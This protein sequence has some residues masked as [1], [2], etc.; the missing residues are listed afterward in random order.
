LWIA[1]SIFINKGY[2]KNI[3]FVFNRF[4][5]IEV[6][7]RSFNKVKIDT[8]EYT[9]LNGF[10][11]IFRNPQKYLYVVNQHQR[12]HEKDKYYRYR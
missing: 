10:F 4:D 7:I 6:L 11:Q 1:S 8:Q 9:H 3:S 12:H 2:N 5:S